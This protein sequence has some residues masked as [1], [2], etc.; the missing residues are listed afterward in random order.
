MAAAAVEPCQAELGAVRGAVETEAVARE[1]AV[2]V[3]DHMAVAAVLGGCQE[4]YWE[5]RRAAAGR[6][7]E[8][9]GEV[10]GV[11]T[12][13]IVREHRCRQRRVATV[14]AMGAAAGAAA[15]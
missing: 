11:A 5:G 6:A 1:A 7:A 13:G 8:V 10:N 4:A 9:T 12:P 3:V 15:R 14:V 2:R